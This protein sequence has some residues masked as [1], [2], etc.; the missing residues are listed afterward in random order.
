MPRHGFIGVSPLQPA[1]A[2]L[3]FL[4]GFTPTISS[5]NP[6]NPGGEAL[7]LV[8]IGLTG[9]ALTVEVALTAALLIL[10]CRVEHRVRLATGLVALNLVSY[11]VFIAFLFPRFPHLFVIEMMIWLLE[12]AGM[13]ILVGG[14]GSNPLK[15]WQALAISFVGNLA[16]FLI[17]E[18]IWSHR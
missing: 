2:G 8:G 11:F 15:W 10:L 16:S 1:I 14:T 4:F 17:G 3:V 18:A 5:A 6:V 13:A 7:G 9:I 12:A